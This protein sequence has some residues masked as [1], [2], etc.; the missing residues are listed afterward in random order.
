MKFKTKGTCSASIE[1]DVSDG[2][3]TNVRF[4]RGCNGNL[5]GIA[6]LVEGMN[7]HE[8]I[9]KLKGINCQNGTSCPDQLATALEKYMSETAGNA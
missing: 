3:L 4:E 8:V 1:F 7:V 9:G 2:I 5:S 6:R